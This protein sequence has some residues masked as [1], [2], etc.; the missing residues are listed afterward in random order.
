MAKLDPKNMLPLRNEAIMRLFRDGWCVE[1]IANVFDETVI[2]VESVIR[3]KV[4]T[5]K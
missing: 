3:E 4:E 2:S 5:I 1:N